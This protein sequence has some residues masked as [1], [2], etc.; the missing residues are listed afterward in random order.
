MT[1][2]VSPE[3]VL[4]RLRT[5]TD[6]DTGQN[7]VAAGQVDS[8]SIDGA[9]AR[10]RLALGA[11]HAPSEAAIADGVRAALDPTIRASGDDGEPVVRREPGE[12]AA[13]FDRLTATVA[14]SVGTL[15]RTHHRETV[16]GDA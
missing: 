4:D 13:A 11:P 12:A 10:V 15:R 9:T 5:V 16:R 3:D 14:D 2:D 7:I 8:V 1:H 6:P